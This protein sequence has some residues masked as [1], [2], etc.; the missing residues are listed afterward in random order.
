MLLSDSQPYCVKQRLLPSKKNKFK[1]S[2]IMFKA[3]SLLFTD[4]SPM[5]LS[6]STLHTIYSKVSIFRIF[7]IFKI[8]R[9]FKIFRL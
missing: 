3:D 8:F 1:V 2:K 5:L 7:R 9:M 4:F 6:I